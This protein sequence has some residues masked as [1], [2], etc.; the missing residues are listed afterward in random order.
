MSEWRQSAE[1]HIPKCSSVP[2]GMHFCELDVGRASLPQ[3]L[4]TSG[5]SAEIDELTAGLSVPRL[6]LLAAVQAHRVFGAASGTS[7]PLRLGKG[8]KMVTASIK[9][10]LSYW[11][12][13]CEGYSLL[14]NKQVFFLY[15]PFGALVLAQSLPTCYSNQCLLFS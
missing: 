6:H 13:G 7:G 3:S 14:T 4:T 8:L 1:E 15:T 2:M 10:G 11:N 9:A 5:S 12:D